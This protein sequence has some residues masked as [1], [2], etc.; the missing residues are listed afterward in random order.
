MVYV[1]IEPSTESITS[2]FDVELLLVL[3]MGVVDAVAVAVAKLVRVCC[4]CIC[5]RIH[6]VFTTV[7][8]AFGS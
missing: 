8:A 7:F 6:F 5:E 4:C 3:M 2:I 1:V